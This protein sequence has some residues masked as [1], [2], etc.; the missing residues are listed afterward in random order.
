MAV[1][2]RVGNPTK[3]DIIVV[4]I[5]QAVADAQAAVQA[6]SGLQDQTDRARAVAVRNALTDLQSKVKRYMDGDINVLIR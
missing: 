2:K 5:A 4:M 3:A 6:N 1:T